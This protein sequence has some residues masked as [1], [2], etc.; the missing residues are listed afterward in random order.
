MIKASV[1]VPVRNGAAV[2]GRCLQALHAQSMA[3]E[4]YEVIVVDDG[5][6]DHTA[7]VAQGF[8]GVLVFQQEA[9]GPAAARNRG[10]RAAQ[11]ETVLFTDADCAPVPHWACALVRAL[12]E[13][14][15]AGAKG[16]YRTEQHGLVARFVQVEYEGKYRRMARVGGNARY[17]SIDFIDTY[18]AAYRR[19]VLEEVGGFDERFPMP[20]VE[21]QEL[22]FR[23]AQRGHRLVFAPDAVV[24][25][26]HA[27]TVGAYARK[28]Y[29]IGYWKALV[30]REHPSKAARD[31]HTPQLLKVEMLFTALLGVAS[32]AGML[33]RSGVPVLAAVAALVASWAP[34]LAHAARRDPATLVIAPVMLLTR[35]VALGTGLVWGALRLRG[36]GARP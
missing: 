5:S 10:W 28:K 3:R 4:E 21:D 16:T 15:A 36:S 25:H 17:A 23:V 13:S 2:L 30:L 19:C 8:P 1:V 27:A 31:S 26:L 33:L 14:G 22:S 34:F 24:D 29:R 7:E 6:C 32:V 9:R 12:D 11:G 35:A 18:S 20:S